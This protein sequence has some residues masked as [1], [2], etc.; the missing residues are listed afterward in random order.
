[1]AIKGNNHDLP[2]D[3]AILD[4]S[5]P[6]AVSWYKHK[7]KD[8]FDKGISVIKAD[9]GE[10]APYHGIYDSGYSGIYEHNLYPFALQQGSG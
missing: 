6:K 10:A 2:T 1:M 8:L 4:F 5:N 7:L 9:F 3:D